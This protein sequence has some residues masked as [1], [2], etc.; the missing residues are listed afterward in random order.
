[1]SEGTQASS[2][3]C[4]HCGAALDV[5]PGTRFA[6]CSYCGRK[7]QIHHTGSAIY[8]EVLDSIEQRTQQMA[9]DIQTLKRQNE[10]EALDRQWA[11]QRAQF[12][13]RSRSGRTSEPS[14]FGSVIGGVVAAVF[15]VIWIAGAA[16]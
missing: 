8:T 6:T 13:V 7:L 4:N 14:A 10:L 12:M 16:S 5:P 9:N 1:M 3:I 2:V 15:G 11:E